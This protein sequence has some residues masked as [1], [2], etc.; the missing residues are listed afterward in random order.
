MTKYKCVNV[1]CENQGLCCYKDR[2]VLNV[3]KRG[4][5]TLG[6]L[7][8]L[9]DSRYRDKCKFKGGVIYET[10]DRNYS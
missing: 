4:I 5:E 1:K 6:E 7:I 3:D 9:A 10:V 8:C 2:K